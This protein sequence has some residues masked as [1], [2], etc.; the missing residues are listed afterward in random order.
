MNPLVKKGA[1]DALMEAMRRQL[2]AMP[3]ETPDDAAFFKEAARQFRRI[4]KLF[5]YEPG[6]WPTGFCS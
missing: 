4:E 5:G 3:D 2:A 6:S 1:Q